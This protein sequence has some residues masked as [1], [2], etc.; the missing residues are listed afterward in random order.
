MKHILEVLQDNGFTF[1]QGFHP[2]YSTMVLGGTRSLLEDS[3][4]NK[5]TWGLNEHK[6]PPTLLH[7]RPKI[8]LKRKYEGKNDIIF[9]NEIEILSELY[10]DAMN[11]CL[12]KESHEEIFKAMF[13]KSIVF[14]YDLTKNP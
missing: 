7:P 1:T 2:N 14:E 3:K 9:E 12:Q 10:D 5:V 11:F 4:G 8:I 13:D 6:K